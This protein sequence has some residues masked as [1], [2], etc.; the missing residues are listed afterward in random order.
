M[1]NNPRLIVLAPG[2][3]GQNWAYETL[4]N[5]FGENGFDAIFA[6][7]KRYGFG[8]I[9]STSFALADAIKTLRPYYEHIT[10]IGHSMGG[11][12]GRYMVQRLDFPIDSCIFIS[13]PHYGTRTAYL[14]PWSQSAYQMRP[15]SDFLKK[16]NNYDWPDVPVLNIQ[17]G[18][19]EIVVPSS[20]AKWRG[21]NLKID[22]ATHLS[23]IYN[24][25]TFWESYSWLTF[26]V[27]G[28][29]PSPDKGNVGTLSI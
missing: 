25:K 23:V 24:E 21:E 14:A 28:E 2:W 27:F 20:S 17:A 11:L 15:N 5:R 12:I 16:L 9:Q 19:E 3:T 4:R 13:T 6:E 18:W 29:S 10:L 1:A 22:R 7:Y 8:P 26:G